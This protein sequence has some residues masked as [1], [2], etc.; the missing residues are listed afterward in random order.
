MKRIRNEMEEMATKDLYQIVHKPKKGLK[1]YE[2]VIDMNPD[3]N[4]NFNQIYTDIYK[5]TEDKADL[6]R[7]MLAVIFERDPERFDNEDD[8]VTKINQNNVAWPKN[9]IPVSTDVKRPKPFM[10]KEEFEREE[11][12]EKHSVIM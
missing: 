1:I 8:E 7:N 10:S 11:L 4:K 6:N 12:K 9:Y 5:H 2:E 3:E